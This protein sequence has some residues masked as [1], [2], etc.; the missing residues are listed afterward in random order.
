MHS[1]IIQLG[2][3][4]IDQE[5]YIQ[6]YS[7]PNWFTDEIADYVNESD[8][9]KDLKWFKRA[10]FGSSTHAEMDEIDNIVTI[11]NA[12]AF[13]EDFFR[14]RFEIMRNEVANMTLNDFAE[15][16][17]AYSIAS[18]ARD[19]FGFYIYIDGELMSFDVFIRSLEMF[20][21]DV[22]YIGGTLDY[23]C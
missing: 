23:H 10:I 4:A 22:F 18:L 15:G 3:S 14:T 5:D 16:F 1:R 8:R 12:Q 13:R 6:D 11:H 2:V 7:I 19:R 21:Q 20:D 17:S 9:E